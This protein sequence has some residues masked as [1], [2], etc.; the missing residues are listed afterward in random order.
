MKIEPLLFFLRERD[1]CRSNIFTKILG[2]RDYFVVHAGVKMH[3]DLFS[4]KLFFI[5]SV[6]GAGGG[7][8]GGG[9]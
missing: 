9:R 2:S 1:K 7:G 6:G 5:Y 4:R 3:E 8:G